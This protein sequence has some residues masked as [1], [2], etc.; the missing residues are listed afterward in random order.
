MG[1]SMHHQWNTSL[2]QSNATQQFALPCIT[3]LLRGLI[4]RTQWLRCTFTWL[5]GAKAM[6]LFNKYEYGPKTLIGTGLVDM[7]KCTAEAVIYTLFRRWPGQSGNNRQKH[8][9]LWSF[10]HFYT[11]N[12]RQNLQYDITIRAESKCLQMLQ[13]VI[14]KNVPKECY[15]PFYLLLLF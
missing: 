15:Q 1:T 3:P 4:N 10:S 7:A 9:Y 11:N 12:C 8:Y 5:R 14:R 2:W 6:Q 13:T